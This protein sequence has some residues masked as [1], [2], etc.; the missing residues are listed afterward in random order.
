MRD[1][2]QSSEGRQTRRDLIILP[3]LSILTLIFLLLGAEIVARKFFV[4]QQVDGCMVPDAAIGF[5]YRPGCATR[6]KAFE[7]PWVVNQYNDCGYRTAA[8]CGTK[9]PGTIRI[10]LIDSNVQFTLHIRYVKM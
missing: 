5:K 9:S 8:G 3:C 1:T 6:V 2:T 10:A 7:G 4:D